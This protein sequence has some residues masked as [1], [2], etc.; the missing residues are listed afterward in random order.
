MTYPN[1]I[2]Q[3]PT[4]IDKNAS[5][6]VISDEYFNVPSSPYEMYLDHVPRDAA[7]T[8]IYASGYILD[9]WTEVFAP[10]SASGEF[11]VDYDTGQI[12][13]WSGNEDR[14]V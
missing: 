4:R 14:A 10:P 2:S 13:F 1:S 5:G 3:Y 9:E 11:Y 6:W 8:H 7:T 12:T